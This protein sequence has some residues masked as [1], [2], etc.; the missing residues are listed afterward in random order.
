VLIAAGLANWGASVSQERQ[1]AR[2]VRAL[3]PALG[4]TATSRVGDVG[5]GDGRLTVPLALGVV[6]AGYVF[7]TEIDLDRLATLRAR[8]VAEALSNVTLI[9]SRA[10]DTGLPPLCCDGVVLRRVYHHLTD[11]ASVLGDLLTAVRPG[12][13]LLVV[14]FEPTGWRGFLPRPDGLPPDRVGHGVAPE[15]VIAEATAAG[16]ELVERLAHWPGSDYALVFARPPDRP[17]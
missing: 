9:E 14:D 13:R 12:G 6:T 1:T 17:D 16:F 4:L 8:V 3:V 7:A 2:E 11:P 10:G 15:T 5:A